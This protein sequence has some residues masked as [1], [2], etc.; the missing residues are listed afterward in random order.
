MS[1]R[2]RWVTAFLDDP[3]ARAEQAA[4]FWA[5][6]TGAE[7]SSRRG[8]E[9]EFASLL[10]ADGDPF[11]AVQ[12][13]AVGDASG[14]HLDLHADD[15]PGLV[16]RAEDLGAAT[17]RQEDGFTVCVSPG[18]LPFC[19]VAHPASQRPSPVAWSLGRSELDQVCL[20]IP[21][22]RWEAESAF[23]HEL[24][25]WP[26][27]PSDGEFRRLRRPPGVPLAFLLQRLDDEQPAVTAHLDLSADHREA[28]TSRHEAL[29]AE[30]VRRTPHWT[31]LRDPSGRTYCITGRVARRCLRWRS[32]RPPSTDWDAIWP[33]FAAVV[34]AGETYAYDPDLTSEQ[35]RALW[36]PGP[37]SCT[38]VAVE[39]GEVLGSA[40]TGPNRP[41]R[42]AHVATASF[43]V[44][45]A[46]R[47]RGVG[48][49]LGEW[50]VRRSRHEG[51]R[52][53]QFNAVV[54]TN[55]AAVTLWRD[56][57]F[58]VVGT[59][60]EAFLHPEHG[61]VGLHVMHLPLR[62]DPR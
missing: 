42:G 38:V 21:P 52:A 16:A 49:L 3:P 61:Y 50:L 7:P 30:L 29:G 46:A 6:V 53:I 39:A 34:R 13:V 60:P 11:L 8:P 44:D 10:P 31:V 55:T 18:E 47:G 35:A 28:E 23:W 17:V 12:R 48:R 19:V 5:E 2:V 37:P 56:L 24:T 54:E 32:G 59:V 58:A 4:S 1:G 33:F 43:M 62:E 20:D 40:T 51:F 15:V 22:S 36:M 25:S 45:P 27:V 57:G 41:G 26:W 9:D 14:L